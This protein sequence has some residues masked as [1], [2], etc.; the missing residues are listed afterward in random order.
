MKKSTLKDQ[1]FTIS[2][3]MKLILF[4]ASVCMLSIQKF[5]KNCDRIFTRKGSECICVYVDSCKLFIMM[6]SC[7]FFCTK[8]CISFEA[9][10][11]NTSI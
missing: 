3:N 6:K 5:C 2:L 1:A 7:F 9:K 11:S 4:I 8:H 10:L